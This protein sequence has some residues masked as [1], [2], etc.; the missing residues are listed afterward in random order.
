MIFYGIG[1]FINMKTGFVAYA[2]NHL[3]GAVNWGN[4]PI[5]VVNKIC[6]VMGDSI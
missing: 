4:L 1:R 6:R 2:Y 5:A 3:R